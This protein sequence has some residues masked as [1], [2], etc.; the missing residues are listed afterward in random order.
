M[1]G[2]SHVSPQLNEY[3]LH[4]HITVPTLEAGQLCWVDEAVAR[5]DAW[6]VDFGD[7]LNGGRLV[8]VLI[9][10]VHFEGVD[11]VFVDGLKR[12]MVSS[13]FW[14]GMAEEERQT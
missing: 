8:G 1:R 3:C 12:E 6:E 14:Q 5:V 11:A 9:T 13:Q 2:M 4:C 10:A 7:E